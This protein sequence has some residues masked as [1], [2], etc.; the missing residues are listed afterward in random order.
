MILLKM[1]NF[2]QL[3]MCYTAGPSVDDRNLLHRGMMQTFVQYPF[4][5][6]AGS[7]GKDDL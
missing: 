5:Y 2:G 6:H 3:W 7:A 4:A 1:D